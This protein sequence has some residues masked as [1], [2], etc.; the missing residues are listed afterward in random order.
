M[1][2][3]KFEEDEEEDATKKRVCVCVCSVG[4]LHKTTLTRLTFDPGAAE[5]TDKIH[6]NLFSL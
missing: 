1:S 3:W 6:I 5:V 4:R 2:R